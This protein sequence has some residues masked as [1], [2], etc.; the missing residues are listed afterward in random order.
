[1]ATFPRPDHRCRPPGE[2]GAPEARAQGG[3]LAELPPGLIPLPEDFCLVEEPVVMGPPGAAMSANDAPLF[4][5]ESPRDLVADDVD[6]EWLVCDAGD[7]PAEDAS[8]AWSALVPSPAPPRPVAAAEPSLAS[9]AWPAPGPSEALRSLLRRGPD[10][11]SLGAA[12][13]P[14]MDGDRFE[15]LRAALEAELGIGPLLAANDG[16]D[17]DVE[18][19]LDE[20]DEAAA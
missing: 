18:L 19:V 11:A 17:P 4:G 14:E 12:D 5:L 6:L 20:D 3:L 2:P 7:G 16:A 9:A 13:L 8:A 1:M 15:S 10:P